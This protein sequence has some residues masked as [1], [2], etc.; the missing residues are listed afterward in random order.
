[1]LQVEHI[2]NAL[3][4]VPDIFEG[5]HEMTPLP[6][7]QAPVAGT[8]LPF[9]A[10]RHEPLLHCPDQVTVTDWHG[11]WAALTVDAIQSGGTLL[12]APC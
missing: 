2:L 9:Q 10:A 12:M 4:Q 7:Q 6:G 8:D 1:M 5:R 11:I 3:A